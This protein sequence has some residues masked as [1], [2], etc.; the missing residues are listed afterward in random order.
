MEERPSQSELRRITQGGTF[1]RQPFPGVLWWLAGASLVIMVI[2]SVLPPQPAEALVYLLGLSPGRLLSGGEGDN[3]LMQVATL[4]THM[5]T[6]GSW[7]HFGLNALWLLIF[8]VPV[9]NRLRW[10]D[11]RG[12]WAYV[13]FLS[14]YF[15]VGVAA[16]L[17]FVLMHLSSMTVL[18]GASG[19]LSGVIGAAMRLELRPGLLAEMPVLPLT[20]PRFVVFTALF[21][22]MNLIL[23]T[24]FAGILYQDGAAQTISWEVHLAGYFIGALSLPF[25]DRLARD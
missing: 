7:G 11:A 25:F 2:V 19:A 22:G 5:F 14:F 1:A 23:L 20:H 10:R 8:G 15:T 12:V 18:I 6:H 21:V 4:I 3:T 17:V 16:G 9:A 13:P 24:P